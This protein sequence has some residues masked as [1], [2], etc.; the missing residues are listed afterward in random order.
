MK[1]TKWK[2][3]ALGDVVEDTVTAFR[4][5][6]VAKTRWLNGCIR[7]TVQ[8]QELKDGKPIDALGFDVEQ[9]ELVRRKAAKAKPLAQATGGPMPDVGRGR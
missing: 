7:I 2:L 8:P 5:V 9:L 3:F 1:P 4:G 6:V